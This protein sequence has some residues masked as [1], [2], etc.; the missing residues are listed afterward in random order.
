MDNHVIDFLIKNEDLVA[1]WV[2]EFFDGKYTKEQ[3]V[4]YGW[5]FGDE[6]VGKAKYGVVELA[7]EFTEL[8]DK[9][10]NTIRQW[11]T[12]TDFY[13]FDLISWNGCQ[14]FKE[15]AERVVEIIKQNNFK[16]V[17]DFG[18]GLGALSIFIR[19]QTDCK[20]YYVDL[21]DGVTY[22]FAKFLMNKF[23]ITDIEVLGDQEF[24]NSN[25]SVDCVFA[26]DCFEHIPNMEET[27]GK[28]T[29]HTYRVY[30]DSTFY[31]D[32]TFPQHVY[33]PQ[34]LDFLNMCAMHN[35]LPSREDA[36][37]MNRM[38]L[39]FDQQGNLSVLPV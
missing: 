2:T 29:E 22:N 20:V 23:N 10:N 6:S 36:R 31:T 12:D 39:Q 18:G 25:I 7:K 5:T 34:I 35:F 28:L 13:V 38:Y 21:K 27:F 26:M 24:F 3:V 33:T 37:M 15:K 8:P 19:Q 16:S 11:Y 30:H 9:D 4:H 14:M 32:A 1:D 17:V